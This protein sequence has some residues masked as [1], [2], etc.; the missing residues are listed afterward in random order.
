MT[1]ELLES[2]GQIVEEIAYVNILRIS[3]TLSVKVK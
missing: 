1:S 3:I 2:Y